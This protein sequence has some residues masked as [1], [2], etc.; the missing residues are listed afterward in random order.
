MDII[1]N[2]VE[3]RIQFLDY[4]PHEEKERKVTVSITEGR[5]ANL[6]TLAGYMHMTRSRLAAELLSTAVDKA[7]EL[8]DDPLLKGRQP[9]PQSAIAMIADMEEEVEV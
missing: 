5:I 4:V 2:F 6:D 9:M 7:A 1:R 8:L 3:E